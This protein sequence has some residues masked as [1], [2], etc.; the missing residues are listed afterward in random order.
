[1]VKRKRSA[2]AQNDNTHKPACTH[3]GI[4]DKENLPFWR[5]VGRLGFN[6]V[7]SSVSESSS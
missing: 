1:M 6:G 7:G 5:K 3:T 4:A 2:K